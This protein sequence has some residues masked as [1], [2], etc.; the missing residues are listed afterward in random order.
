VILHTLIFIYAGWYF[1]SKNH[2]IKKKN[3]IIFGVLLSLLIYGVHLIKSDP[4]QESG[5]KYIRDPYPSITAFGLIFLTIILT[6]LRNF[7]IRKFDTQIDKKL[8]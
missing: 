8:N 7:L 2:P 6:L 1:Y 3:I 5:Y 4:E